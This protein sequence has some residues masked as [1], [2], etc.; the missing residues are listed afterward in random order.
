MSSGSL[1]LTMSSKIITVEMARKKLGKKGERLTDKQIS[2]ILSMLRFIC[3]KAI[4]GVIEGK[5]DY[6]N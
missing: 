3:N 1:Y 2:D 5:A 4:D 6:E